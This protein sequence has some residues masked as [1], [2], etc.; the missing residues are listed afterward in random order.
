MAKMN[1]RVIR[2]NNSNKKLV[3]AVSIA[4]IVA[5]MIHCLYQWSVHQVVRPDGIFTISIILANL[6][7]YIANENA[8]SDKDERDESPAKHAADISYFI[9]IISI[10]VILFISEG[11][12][13]FVELENIPLVITFSLSIV[14]YPLVRA[15]VFY[16][17]NN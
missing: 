11:T 8:D 14:I 9:L 15:I 6:L 1:A 16:K 13:L 12:G 3:Y 5:I 7:H 17:I 10:G 4:S 2:K